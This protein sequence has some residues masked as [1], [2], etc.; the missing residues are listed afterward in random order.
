VHAELGAL[1]LGQF[2]PGGKGGAGGR[3]SDRFAARLV[4]RAL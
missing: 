2:L 4:V 1:V 3:H